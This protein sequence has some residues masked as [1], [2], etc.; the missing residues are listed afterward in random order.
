MA[1]VP[2]LKAAV[3]RSLNRKNAV[4]A[5]WAVNPDDVELVSVVPRDHRTLD[6]T[7]RGKPSQPTYGTI[8]AQVYRQDIADYFAKVALPTFPTATSVHK[9][10]P[11]LTAQLGIDFALADFVDN[12]ITWVG[13]NATVTFQ[14]TEDSLFW[15]GTAIVNIT[16]AVT[17]IN[18]VYTLV[19]LNLTLKAANRQQWIDYYSAS[20]KRTIDETKVDVGNPQ[21]PAELGLTST[22]NTVIALTAKPNSGLSG[23]RYVFY[24]RVDLAKSFEGAETYVDN[25]FNGTLYDALVT[26]NMGLRN[27]IAVEEVADSVLDLSAWPVAAQL[28]PN[29]L[30]FKTFGV[31]NVKLLRYQDDIKKAVLN[32]NSNSVLLTFASFAASI[33]A[34]VKKAATL[35]LEINVG[36]G[37][38]LCGASLAEPTLS[39]KPMSGYGR[40]EIYL[41]NRGNIYG[42]GSDYGAFT[43]TS[44]ASDAINVS[45]DFMGKIVINNLGNIAG[46]AV[47]GHR[48]RVGSIPVTA[49]AE[50]R[51]VRRARGQMQTTTR[52]VMRT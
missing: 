42:R 16:T 8:T 20:G 9:L 37:V 19:N 47:V 43:V 17:D 40:I 45:N 15:F 14:A 51:S 13:S 52:A 1:Y 18:S 5:A 30:S 32:F 35:Q 34:L 4:T 41:T 23:V 26:D 27:L 7:V 25:A 50:C 24:T 12:P 44:V 29:P 31:A 49:V 6:V 21:D 36:A 11:D 39:F 2:D 46:V 33:Q 28:K 3:I 10:L 38:T 48:L 22:Y